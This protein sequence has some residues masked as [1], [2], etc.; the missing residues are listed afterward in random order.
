MYRKFSNI[1]IFKDFSFICPCILGFQGWQ[2][3]VYIY[4]SFFIWFFLALVSY[5]RLRER[6]QRMLEE[7]KK[8]TDTFLPSIS[9][10]N[11][12]PVRPSS[13]FRL[14][15]T[16]KDWSRV[17]HG[18]R[19]MESVIRPGQLMHFDETKY[20]PRP[21]SARFHVGL[22]SDRDAGRPFQRYLERWVHMFLF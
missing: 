1:P 16:Q 6:H 22:A 20:I 17:A 9:L 7:A 8:P 12:L 2:V 5:E 4:V 21:M 13:C 18:G 15:T 14:A 10:V 19:Q 11:S 3:C